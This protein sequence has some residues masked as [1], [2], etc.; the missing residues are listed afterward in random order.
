[1]K[2]NQTN[3]WDDALFN[4]IGKE[5]PPDS[6]A[7]RNS[8]LENVLLDQDGNPIS[9]HRIHEEI[10]GFLYRIEQRALEAGQGGRGLIRAPYATG[11]SQQVA[12][13]LPTYIS[14]RKPEVE[15]LI[16]SA[17][18]SISTKRIIAIRQIVQSNEY[19]YWCSDH[20]LKPLAFDKALD[21][22]STEKITFKSKNRTG[23]PS[24]EAQAVLSKTTGQR[25]GYV[26]FDDI[27][28]DDD[29][30]SKARRQQVYSRVT[31]TW[32]KRCHDKGFVF[33]ICT[34]Y[35]PDDANS[36]LMRSGVFDVMQIAVKE[37]RSGYLLKEWDHRE[38]PN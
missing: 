24:M 17:D 13:A 23:N 4:V 25:A 34:P 30:T 9:Q 35:H 2:R 22:G 26:W 33:D 15:H 29:K 28:N 18:G 10:Q 7:L 6:L 14:T 5:P 38:A 11:K 8:F 32:I 16:I 31:N 37:D 36:K 12:V 19:K 27:C 20:N 3:D 21:T 1:M